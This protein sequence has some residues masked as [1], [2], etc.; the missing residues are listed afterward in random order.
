MNCSRARVLGVDESPATIGFPPLFLVLLIVD[1][2]IE[3]Q[4]GLVLVF[5]RKLIG[6]PRPS[7]LPRK[8]RPGL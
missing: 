5:S 8:Y 1:T 6:L 7:P 4:M 2:N 3:H